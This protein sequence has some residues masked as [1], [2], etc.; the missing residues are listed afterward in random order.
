VVPPG[1]VTA[2]RRVTSACRGAIHC[3]P[4]QAL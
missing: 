4:T 2:S 1:F 3:A